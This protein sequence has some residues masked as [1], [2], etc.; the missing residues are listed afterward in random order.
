MKIKIKQHIPL[1]LEFD[2]PEAALTVSLARVDL[3]SI[4]KRQFKGKKL[5]II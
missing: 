4:I 1:E 5:T 3:P 2:V